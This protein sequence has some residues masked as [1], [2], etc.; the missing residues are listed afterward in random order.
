MW[1]QDATANE[2]QRQDIKGIICKLQAAAHLQPNKV[3]LV[4]HLPPDGSSICV[5]TTGFNCVSQLSCKSMYGI[6]GDQLFN[7]ESRTGQDYH[8]FFCARR[9]RRSTVKWPPFENLF[10]CVWPK[11]QKQNPWGWHDAPTSSSEC[12][13]HSPDRAA[14]LAFTR[15][16]KY[17]QICHWLI[18]SSQIRAGSGWI[19]VTGKNESRDAIDN[20]ILHITLSGRTALVVGQWWPRETCP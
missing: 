8:Q 4:V 5:V 15:E 19:H 11:C 10:A 17:W 1:V 18:F 12:F 2:R 6:P 16:H 20:V 7:R 14:W 3:A 13:A 9:N